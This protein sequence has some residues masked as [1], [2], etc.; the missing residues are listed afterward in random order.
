LQKKAG[1]DRWGGS[2]I[3]LL[4]KSRRID[5]LKIYWGGRSSERALKRKVFHRHRNRKAA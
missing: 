2:H 4:A 1:R 5:D 3:D